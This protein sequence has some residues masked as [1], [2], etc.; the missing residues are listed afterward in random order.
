[1]HSLAQSE[2]QYS[3]EKGALNSPNWITKCQSNKA[4]LLLLNICLC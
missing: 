2:G 3:Q 1:M 4:V